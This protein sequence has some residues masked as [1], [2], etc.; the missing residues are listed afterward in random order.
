M[1]KSNYIKFILLLII[2]SKVITI[3]KPKRNRIGIVPFN[4]DLLSN[5]NMCLN[6]TNIFLKKNKYFI[7]INRDKEKDEKT[8]ITDYFKKTYKVKINDKNIYYYGLKGNVII[9]LV[10]IKDKNNVNKGDLSDF[11]NQNNYSWKTFFDVN[12]EE[13][14]KMYENILNNKKY[15]LHVNKFLISEEKKQ[16]ILLEDLYNFFKSYEIH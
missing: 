16:K 9:Y 6:M 12:F 1:N 7:T 4:I 2:M 15:N 14:N 11:S 13:N 5:D 8:Q 10:K 3:K